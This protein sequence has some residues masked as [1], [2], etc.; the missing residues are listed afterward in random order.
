MLLCNTNESHDMAKRNRKSQVIHHDF[1][2]GQFWLKNLKPKTYKQGQVI[3]SW[4]DG[5]NL[6]L[7]GFAGTGKS[8]LALHLGLS[9]VRANE[10]D[11]VVIVRS[12]VPTREIGHL[13][14]SE[15]EKI[16]IYEQPY[17]SLC[18]QLTGE[19]NAYNEL[20]SAGQIDFISTSFIR[21]LTLDNKV[22]FID[23]FQNL[24]GHELDSILTRVGRNTRIILSGDVFQSDF[25]NDREKAS[26]VA[27]MSI[28]NKCES[29]NMI[30]FD[31]YEDIVRS[32]FVRE[33]IIARRELAA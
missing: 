31:Q 20:K 23:E 8:Y 24:N 14:G 22:L 6:V 25:R 13:P 33:Y 5:K 26:S 21:G 18:H 28:L 17:W 32:D 11:Q 3:Q 1:R 29:F 2:Y 16:G 27:V 4:T 12:I 7:S 19:V 10:Q 15:Q 9:A 30:E